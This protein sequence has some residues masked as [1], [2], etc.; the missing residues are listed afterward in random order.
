MPD[1]TVVTPSAVVPADRLTLGATHARAWPQHDLPTPPTPS[2][3]CVPC[4]CM[5]EE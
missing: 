3:A 5:A 1:L 4:N 2:F